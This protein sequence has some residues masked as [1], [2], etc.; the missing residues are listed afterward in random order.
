MRIFGEFPSNFCQ[1]FTEI[2][3]KVRFLQISAIFPSISCKFLLNFPHIGLKI[4]ASFHILIVFYDGCLKSK[5]LYFFLVFCEPINVK[6]Q[7]DIIF[8]FLA[9]L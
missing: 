5:F 1:Y 9:T 4:P 8:L 6:L 7:G 3:E 2:K